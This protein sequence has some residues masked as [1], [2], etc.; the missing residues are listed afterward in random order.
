LH[1]CTV[2]L[3]CGSS[4]A[5]ST[6]CI[7]LNSA[8]TSGSSIDPGMTGTLTGTSIHMVVTYTVPVL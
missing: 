3:V 2:P 8:Y 4:D 7:I 1:I 5:Y 6:S